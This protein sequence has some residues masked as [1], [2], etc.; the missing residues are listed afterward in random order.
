MPATTPTAA[1]PGP[2]ERP[3]M[4]DVAAALCPAVGGASAFG[5]AAGAVGADLF[6]AGTTAPSFGTNGQADQQ[7]GHPWF[8]SLSKARVLR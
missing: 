6:T 1:A 2:A 3:A 4:A 5:G 7:A 8:W